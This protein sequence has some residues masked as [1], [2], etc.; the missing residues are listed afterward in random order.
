[1]S[2]EL[3]KLPISQALEIIKRFRLVI[4]VVLFASIYVYLFFLINTLTTKKPSQAA[5]DQELRT[6]KRL[7]VDENAV[8]Q[9]L[10][11]TEESIEVK[12]IYEETRNNPFSEPADL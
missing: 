5:V 11:L 12:A 10:Q 8:N 2:E 3:K 4:F 9:M 7:K 6:V 1:M